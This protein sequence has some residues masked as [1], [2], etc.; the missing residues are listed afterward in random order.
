MPLPCEEGPVATLF[1]RL[2]KAGIFMRKMP[3]VFRWQDL[4]VTLPFQSGGRSDPVGDAVTGGVF[5]GHDAGAGGRADLTGSVAMSEAH[6]LFGDTVYMGRFVVCAAFNG[7]VPYPEVIRKNENDVGS[8]CK[9]MGPCETKKKE[10][11]KHGGRRLSLIWGPESAVHSEQA[12]CQ[13]LGLLFLFCGWKDRTRVMESGTE[14]EA[15][16]LMGAIH[17]VGLLLLAVPSSLTYLQATYEVS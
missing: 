10:R 17:F 7:E 15:S 6:T 12:N 5:A 11:A 4:V 14:P 1:E 2:G 8:V 13:I 3:D 16:G 9:G